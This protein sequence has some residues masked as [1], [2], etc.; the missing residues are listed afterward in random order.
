MRELHD[1]VLRSMCETLSRKIE[2]VCELIDLIFVEICIVW[3]FIPSIVSSMINY[4]IFGLG[5]Y[6]LFLLCPILYVVP[7]ST[8]YLFT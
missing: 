6:S 1:P 7:Q 2:K 5:E 3:S 4:Y 8:F